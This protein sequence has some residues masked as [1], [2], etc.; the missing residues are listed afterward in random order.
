MLP[1][2]PHP[3]QR[4]WFTA[5]EIVQWSL[6]PPGQCLN[7]WVW[8]NPFPD[9]LRNSKAQRGLQECNLK[10]TVLT[11]FFC[12]VWRGECRQPG[13]DGGAE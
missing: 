1:F 2:P 3:P 9:I 8:T 6:L 12:P 7:A 4:Q 13:P 5:A 11:F 10:D